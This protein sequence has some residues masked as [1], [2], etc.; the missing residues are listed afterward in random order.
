MDKK[1]YIN[2]SIQG[3]LAVNYKPMEKLISDNIQRL[4]S[5]LTKDEAM[6]ELEEELFLERESRRIADSYKVTKGHVF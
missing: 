1:E 5:N 6:D 2:A 4:E 3:T